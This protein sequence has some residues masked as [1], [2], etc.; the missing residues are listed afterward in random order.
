MSTTRRVAAWK[1]EA[2]T[3][4]E[5]LL[6]KYPVIAAADLTKVRSSQIH[7]LRKRLR[8]RVAMVVTKN[9]LLRKSVELSESSNGRVGEFVKDLQGSNILLFTDV[10]PYSLIILLEKSKVRVPAKAG[11]IATGEIM[12]P[13]GNTG[14]P[15]GPVISEFG[16][17]K[18]QTR[19][20][21]GSIWVARDSV[22]A[23]RGDLITPKMASVLSKL[24]LKPM[25][26]GLT[27][28]TAYDNGTILRSEDLVLDIATYR[29]DVFQ[30]VN[31]AF[32]LS[33]DAGYVTPENAP[34]ILGKGMREALA[35][36]V[37]AGFLESGTIEPVLKR[38]VMNA[39]ALNQKISSATPG[40]P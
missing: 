38:A 33:I 18:V 3:Q 31:N 1:K 16:E 2:I 8:D 15:P 39:N 34:R 26:A 19:I 4:L 28:S 24:G 13:A 20:E 35:I 9:N 7:E 27:L 36:A 17:I 5:V 25:E 14:L 32:S 30:A 29:K 6:E 23:R 37:E 21:G 22:V 11:D 10:N 40:N 12:V